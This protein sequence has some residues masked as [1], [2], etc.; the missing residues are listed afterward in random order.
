MG[1]AF[2]ISVGTPQR[3]HLKM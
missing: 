1:N 3:D 2:K